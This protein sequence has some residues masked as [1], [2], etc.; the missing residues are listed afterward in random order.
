MSATRSRSPRRRATGAARAARPASRHGRRGRGAAGEQ[1]AADD[2]GHPPAGP[3]AERV[4]RRMDK[5]TDRLHL[6]VAAVRRQRRELHADSRSDA[7]E[8]RAGSGGRRPH[9]RGGRDGEKQRRP[10]HPR[11]LRRDRRGA[12]PS[13]GEQ[14]GADDHRDRPAGPD[15]ERAP[16][17][18]ENE[19][20]GYSYQ[21]LQCNSLGE[22]C[23]PISAAKGRPTCSRPAMSVTRSRSPRRRATRA[24]PVR[25]RPRL[26][27][28]R[29][30]RKLR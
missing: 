1:Q 8:L 26:R 20:T 14:H 18:L 12:P 22:G 15:A 16:R 29:C 30:S 24:G 9:D 11:Q 3:D 23:L 28:P 7:P 2:R 19:P 17:Q 6:P 21:W 27:P 5:R 10:E 13:A 25:R 4:P